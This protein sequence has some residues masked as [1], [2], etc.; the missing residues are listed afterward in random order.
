MTALDPTFRIATEADANT[1]LAFMEQYY[2]F[3]GHGWDPHLARTALRGLLSNAMFGI[4]WLVLDEQTPVGYLVLT[5]GYSLEFCGRDAFIDE[6]FLLPSHRGRG[7]GRQ[8]LAFL[9]EQ[10]R[11]HDVRAIHLEV[12]RGNEAA[13]ELYRKNSYEDHDHRLMTKWIERR[14]SKPSAPVLPRK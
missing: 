11:A 13:K 6:F 7:W 10:A 5:F 8:A 14:F 1:L 9:E 2:A 4:A 12:V 3:D